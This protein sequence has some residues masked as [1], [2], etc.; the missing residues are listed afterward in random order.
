LSSWND[1]HVPAGEVISREQKKLLSTSLCAN[2]GRGTEQ[3]GRFAQRESDVLGYGACAI[4]RTAAR[5][6]HLTKATADSSPRASAEAI[7]GWPPNAACMRRQVRPEW[8][9]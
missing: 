2:A 5:A 8:L 9:C 6:M 7:G 4:A 3:K 1:A